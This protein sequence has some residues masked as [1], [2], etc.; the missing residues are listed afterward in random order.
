MQLTSFLRVM[1]YNRG[2]YDVLLKQAPLK[3]HLKK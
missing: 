1:N 3:R 2:V